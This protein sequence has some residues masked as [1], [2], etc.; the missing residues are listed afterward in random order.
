MDNSRLVKRKSFPWIGLAVLS[1]L[2][3]VLLAQLIPEWR[4]MAALSRVETRGDRL[5][6]DG[7]GAEAAACW[8][9]VLARNPRS[10]TARNKL[11][12][13]HI[14]EGRFEK[15][16]KMLK[17][18]LADRPRELSYLYNLGLLHFMQG[19]YQEA[20]ALLETVADI[21]PMHGEV[22]FLKG[23]IYEK[24]GR[25]DLAA[26][27]FIKELNVDPA[28][29]EAWRKVVAVNTA[30]AMAVAGKTPGADR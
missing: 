11:A 3:A 13:W 10:Y 17:E 22:H 19:R 25:K 29:P 27:E 4:R 24:L 14:N 6:Q 5:F 23:T 1:V 28:T 18:G 8:R 30:P 7:Q 21:N 20:L 15:A 9:N 16:E 26:A 12:I 2:L